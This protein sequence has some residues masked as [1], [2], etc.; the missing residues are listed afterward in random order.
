MND[1]RWKTSFEKLGKALLR[2]E[3]VLNE[4]LDKEEFVLDATI[5][6]FEFS[7]ELF[8][9]ALK[10]L[11]QREG[12]EKEL[13]REILQEAYRAGW[14]ENEE[15]WIRMLR[16]RNLTSHT[17]EQERALLIYDHIQDY[18]PLMKQAYTYLEQNVIPRG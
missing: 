10:H 2:L 17:Y 14:I 13:P 18:F 6:R 9:K 5:Q 8:W 16:D 4:P 11:L 3:E 15:T 7:V 1:K 12:V